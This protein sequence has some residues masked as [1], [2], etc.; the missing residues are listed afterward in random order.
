MTAIGAYTSVCE[1]DA[2]WIGQYLA[3]AERLQ[4]PFA[5]HL[6][7]CSRE[8]KKRFR[9]H[10]LCFAATEQDNPKLEFDETQKQAVFDKVEAAGFQWAMAWD[11]DETYER[12]AGRKLAEIAA[13]DADH[14]DIRWL[15]L[16]G[17]AQ[18]IRVDPPLNT[19]HRVKFYRF[20]N[21]QWRFTHKITNGPKPVE[22]EPVLAKYDFVCLHWGLITRELRL[23]HKARWDRIYGAAV[24]KNPY[25][26]W[27]HCL[28][29]NYPA[30][31]AANEYA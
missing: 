22:R 14:V 24:G 11:I 27:S 15:N 2:C 26:F 9:K 4:L 12:E 25:S 28:D 18:H 30:V 17:D 13:L 8:T 29:D 7:R 19:G 6:D 5:V 20:G 3:E 1:E 31:V 16:W 10:P 23:L 21:L